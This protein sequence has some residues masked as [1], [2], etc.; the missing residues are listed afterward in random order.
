MTSP[1]SPILLRHNLRPTPFKWLWAKYVR[2]VNPDR[3]CTQCLKGW[4]SKRLSKHNRLLE[5]SKELLLDERDSSDWFGIYICGVRGA[6]YPRSNYPH[7]LH[8]VLVPEPERTD[9]FEF[10]EWSMD[11]E[12]ARF[13]PIQNERDLVEPFV[14]KPP[15]FTT[16][17]I[18]RWAVSTL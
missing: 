12:N 14:S 5:H 4:Y 10:E 1:A 13:V 17:R 8:A 16:C 15:E 2:A 9:S 6:G 7:N 3:H 18:F 11:V